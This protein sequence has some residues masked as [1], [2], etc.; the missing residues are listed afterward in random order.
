M[1]IGGNQS[2]P[3]VSVVIPTLNEAENL[4]YV[5]P[6][7]PEWVDEVLLVDGHSTDGTVQ[8]ACE[9]LPSIR[10]LME[11]KRGKGAALRSGYLAS[12][13]D[14]VI[15]LDGDGS[16]DP[17]EIPAFVGAL[18]A[19]ADYAKGT[20]FI[21]GAGTIDMPRYRQFGNAVLVTIANV[22]F[23]ANFSDITFGYNAIW[24][25]HIN[26]LA[27]EIDGWPSE[28]ISNIRMQCA[29]LK[30][31][32]VACFEHRRIHGFAKLQ[33]WSAG[34][35]ILK[36]MLRE[37]FNTQQRPQEPERYGQPDLQRMSFVCLLQTI[38]SEIYQLKRAHESQRLNAETYR[39]ALEIADIAYKSA[40][41]MDKLH[42]HDRSVQLYFREYYPESISGLVVR[43]LG[44]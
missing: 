16:T 4:Q 32:E 1:I 40:L 23:N 8:V 29:G 3:T 27:L 2:Y 15:A 28:I 42:P 11:S 18:L 12:T 33:A 26:S 5:L 31:V 19:G 35:Q 14:I 43:Q 20:R 39:Q 44:I 38:Y 25:Q 22:L 6:R 17:R 36:A 24:R 34:W 37:R 30:V 13:G 7:I 21:Q 10:I 9:L 41:T